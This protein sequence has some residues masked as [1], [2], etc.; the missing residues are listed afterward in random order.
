MKTI[1]DIEFE[2]IEEILP[3]ILLHKFA[4]L[5]IKSLGDIAKLSP[6][7]LLKLRVLE[8]NQLQ[9]CYLFRREYQQI[10]KNFWIVCDSVQS[11]YT[12]TK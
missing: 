12:S 9:I 8:R 3:S 7:D 5:G 6:D 1:D 4:L 2:I 11:T 10:Q